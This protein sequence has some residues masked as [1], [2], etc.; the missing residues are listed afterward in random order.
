MSHRTKFVI[1]ICL[2]VLA[3]FG[4]IAI[5]HYPLVAGKKIMLKVMPVDPRSLMR[6]DYV[7]LRYEVSRPGSL[8]T[9]LPKG[10]VYAKL[11]RDDDGIYHPEGYFVDR[12]D[13][14]PDEAVLKGSVDYRG[15]RYGIETY[16]V[17][18]GTGN[19][20]ENMTRTGQVYAVIAVTRGGNATLVSLVSGN[21]SKL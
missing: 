21:G 8:D 4:M 5:K 13:I 17:E 11:K 1:I 10:R 15:A 3:L 20:I 12:P 6:G 7:D 9:F 16:F 2:Q 19:N 14:G 18:E